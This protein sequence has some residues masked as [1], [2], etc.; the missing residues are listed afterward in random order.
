M[1]AA[2]LSRRLRAG[3]S[4]ELEV[5]GQK[6]T[7]AP[8]EVDVW[9]RPREGYTVAEENGYVVAI[10]TALT[11][12]LVREGLAREVVRRIQ[13]MRKDAD[14]RIEDTIQAWYEASP[15]LE[16]VFGTW[17]DYIKQETLCTALLAG[18]APE[19]GFAAAQDIDEHKLTLCLLRNEPK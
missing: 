11:D 10:S 6:V 16:K 2:E 15:E 12:E 3:E 19:P 18:Q 14:F 17:G 7:L 4:V 13:T 5:E 9:S 8:E 1:D